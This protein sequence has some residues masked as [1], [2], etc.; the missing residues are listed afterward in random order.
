MT[1]LRLPRALRT[2]A[3]IGAALAAPAPSAHA[4]V[5]LNAD[6]VLAN[7]YVWRGL[8]FTNRPVLQ[9]DAYLTVGAGAGA[10][11]AGAALNVEP[12]AYTGA[13]DLS[14]LGAESGTLVTATTLWGEYTRPVGI[15]SATLG[16]AGYVYPHANG[17]AAAY[18]TMELYAKGSLAAPLAPSLAVYYDVGQVRGAYLEAGLRH[19]ITASRRLSFAVAGTAGVSAGQGVHRDGEQTAYFA[20]NGLTHVALSVSAAWAAGRVTVTPTV[21]ALVDHDVATQLTSPGERHHG[22]LLL[23]VA[24]GWATP[25]GR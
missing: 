14:I 17:I 1:S 23:G 11:V 10:F 8:T 21:H 7:A 3:V 9:P 22:K 4:Q 15:A 16:V 2:L 5:A 19:T 18:N 20:G 12:V 25:L 6:L 13:R 24:F